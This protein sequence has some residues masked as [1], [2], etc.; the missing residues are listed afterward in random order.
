MKE[1]K[2]VLLG[3]AVFSV[4]FFAAGSTVSLS[5]V[6]LGQTN[7]TEEAEFACEEILRSGSDTNKSGSDTNKHIEAAE[8]ALA[9]NNTAA[10]Q[11]LLALTQLQLALTSMESR[12]EMTGDQISELLEQESMNDGDPNTDYYLVVG[13]EVY[14]GS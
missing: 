2:E 10:A 6:A 14:C 7:M 12:G 9:D 3:V 4:L 8:I 1:G 13:T 11:D 5:S